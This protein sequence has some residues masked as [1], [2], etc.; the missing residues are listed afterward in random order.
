MLDLGLVSFIWF[1]WFWLRWAGLVW[2]GL[3]GFV[4]VKL[5]TAWLDWGG[6]SWTD[7]AR[8]WLCLAEVSGFRLKFNSLTWFGLNLAWLSLK[9]VRLE[10]V[11]LVVL[12]WVDVC[13]VLF[14]IFSSRNVNN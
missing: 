8:S 11:G 13:C 4:W 2:L 7:R 5:K 14:N 1:S 6:L 12:V 9:G 10:L 3:V